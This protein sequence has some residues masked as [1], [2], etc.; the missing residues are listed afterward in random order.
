MSKTIELSSREDIE[1]K[2]ITTKE[3]KK[4]KKLFDDK[5]KYIDPKLLIQNPY[6]DKWFNVNDNANLDLLR[7]SIRKYGIKNPLQITQDNII[8]GGHTRSY[9]AIQIGLSSVPCQV[10]RYKLTDNELKLHLIEDNYL[11]KNATNQQKT[12]LLNDLVEIIK[13]E[14][15]NW[16]ELIRESF[17]NLKTELVDRFD[18]SNNLANNVVKRERRRAKVEDAEN[19]GGAILYKD[20]R[21]LQEYLRKFEELYLNT[22]EDT[23]VRIKPFVENTIRKTLKIKLNR[24]EN[25]QSNN[26]TDT[27]KEDKPQLN[28][29]DKELYR[30]ANNHLIKTDKV[31]KEGITR[32]GLLN[33]IL[34]NGDKIYCIQC[35]QYGKRVTPRFHHNNNV[36]YKCLDCNITFSPF[37]GS[38]LDGSYLPPDKWINLIILYIKSP[39]LTPPEIA[40]IL[41]QSGWQGIKD[42]NEKIITVFSSINCKDSNVTDKA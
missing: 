34:S 4:G 15:S 30:I 10:A 14:Y 11:N 19:S 6:Q 3:R 36:T 23:K 22:S 42:A 17:N 7:E 41:G 38:L 35:N 20:F 27:V 12:L 39:E 21:K 26:V 25:D 1:K 28:L 24:L 16:E 9:L 37:K 29:F 13:Q 31:F 8:I 40:K 2:I 5:I 18:I 33:T 32:S